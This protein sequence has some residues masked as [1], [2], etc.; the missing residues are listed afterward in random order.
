MND[1]LLLRVLPESDRALLAPSLERV[2]L[3]CGTVLEMP[4][5]PTS[6]AFFLESG[7][8]AV[9]AH[10]P[11]RRIGI[12]VV[13]CDG[14]TAMEVIHNA[15]RAANETIVQ[16]D[17]TAL[18]IERETL[19]AAMERSP[20]LRHVL[21]RY[22]HFF[23]VQ[24]SQTALTNC[25][26]LVEERLARWILMSHDRMKDD[27]LRVTHQFIALML[28]VRRAGIT[29][30]IHILEGRHLVKSRRNS[31]EVLDRQGLID[32]TNGVYGICEE[33]YEHLIDRTFRQAA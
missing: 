5:Q 33:E 17:G 32:I 18:R 4:R 29:S 28:G 22:A 8:A 10:Q 12:G 20:T 6:H 11:N 14:I 1:N 30:A 19:R 25:H 27:V 2:A 15:D 23:E 26:A 13:G 31:L 7:L 16:A 21:L 3:R 24:S 9:V